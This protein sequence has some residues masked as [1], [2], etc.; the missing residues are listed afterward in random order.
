MK[1]SFFYNQINET[2]DYPI[3]YTV[4]YNQTTIIHTIEEMF[5][6]S[7]ITSIPMDDKDNLRYGMVT[8]IL[9]R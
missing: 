6:S 5:N 7:N 1:N 9:L 4:S 2:D 3:L 8:T